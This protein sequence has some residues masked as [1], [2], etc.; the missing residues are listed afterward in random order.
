M[1]HHKTSCTNNDNLVFAVREHH[2]NHVAKRQHPNIDHNEKSNI[3]LKKRYFHHDQ[4]L[5]VVLNTTHFFAI[6]IVARAEQYFLLVGSC[7]G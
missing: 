6:L 2:E 1:E 7:C 4:H 3:G 5:D